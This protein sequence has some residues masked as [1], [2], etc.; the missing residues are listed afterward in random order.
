MAEEKKVAEAVEEAPAKKPAKKATKKAAPKAEKAEAKFAK[1]TTHDFTVIIDPVIT[2]KTMALMQ[3]SNKVT[4]RVSANSNK[5][6][7]KNAFQRLFQ[8]KVTDVKIINVESKTTTRGGRYQGSIPGFKKA[9]VTVAS[10]EAIDL[11]KE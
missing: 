11:F 3:N 5:V 7:I 2:E 10:G 6:E 1:P 8:V 9:I 4:V